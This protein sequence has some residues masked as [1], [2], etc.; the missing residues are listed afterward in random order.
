VI[1]VHLIN[2]KIALPNMEKIKTNLIRYVVQIVSIHIRIK[3]LKL[4]TSLIILKKAI[5]P[6]MGFSQYVVKLTEKILFN[7]Y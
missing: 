3:Y 5:D 6:I 1:I 4:I 2:A 7:I